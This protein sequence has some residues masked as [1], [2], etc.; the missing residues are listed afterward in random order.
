MSSSL[1]SEVVK[2]DATLSPSVTAEDDA[3]WIHR[4]YDGSSKPPPPNPNHWTTPGGD[5]NPTAS[6]SRSV[7]ANGSY[8]WGSTA[9]L[10][11][12]VQSWLDNPASN[13]GWLV[14]G[15]EVQ[16]VFRLSITSGG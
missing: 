8:T 9:Q 12:D 2:T 7:G 13:F 10:A 4:F 11:A 15:P 1:S 5:F 3:T 14:K 6:A 16:D